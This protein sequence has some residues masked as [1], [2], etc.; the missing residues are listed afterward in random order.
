MKFIIG[1]LIGGGIG[2]I[3]GTRDGRERFDEM[4]TGLQNLVGEEVVQQM[5]DFLDQRTAD[6]RKAAA[7]GLDT[8][9]DIIE[10]RT[11]GNGSA[12]AD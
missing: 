7:E 3:L 11:A 12:T 9:A 8:A 10:D 1:L 6:V 4:V 5:T 2:Y